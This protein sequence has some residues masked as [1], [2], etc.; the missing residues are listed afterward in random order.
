MWLLVP[1]LDVWFWHD[2]PLFIMES[3][4]PLQIMLWRVN[5]VGV[6]FWRVMNFM[7]KVVWSV[8]NFKGVW[9]AG[10]DICVIL[11]T[12][13]ILHAIVS[14][15]N[16]PWDNILSFSI[17]F[18]NKLFISSTKSNTYGNYIMA[19]TVVPSQN[20]LCLIVCRGTK[21]YWH[22]YKLIRRT[23]FKPTFSHISLPT[24]LVRIIQVQF[25]CMMTSSNGNVFRVTGHLCGEFP[26]SRNAPHKGQWRGALVFSL[27]CAW[28]NG[29][30]NNRLAGDLRRYCTHY[31]VT[32][33]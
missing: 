31:H 11:L 22:K 6:I 20:R 18:L 10:V 4:L 19:K 32:V 2:T 9:A 33:M 7:K 16:Y 15:W 29:W 30:V 23:D 25:R 28:I 13:K 14:T 8:F 1:A 26:G 17:W 21:S 24:I 5:V 12:Y 3:S 27:I